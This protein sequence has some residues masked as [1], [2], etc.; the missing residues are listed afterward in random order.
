MQ[1]TDYDYMIEALSEDFHNYIRASV[2]DIDDPFSSHQELDKKIQELTDE[3]SKLHEKI[4]QL[5]KII[6]Y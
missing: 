6:R 2:M 3:N 1:N 4:N 5:E